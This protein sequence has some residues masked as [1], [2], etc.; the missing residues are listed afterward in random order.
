M[1][2]WWKPLCL[3]SCKEN[4][5]RRYREEFLLCPY[6][7]KTSRTL[8]MKIPVKEGLLA[9]PAAEIQLLEG[10]GHQLWRCVI[11]TKLIVPQILKQTS[12]NK[13]MCMDLRRFHFSIEEQ[14]ARLSAAQLTP[15]A[16]AL[17]EQEL[18]AA[19]QHKWTWAVWSERMWETLGMLSGCHQEEC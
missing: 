19:L 2:V 13:S 12:S 18:S 10:A 11:N 5:C 7:C 6:F 16:R 1:C 8:V 15:P 9:S 4:A 17:S 14:S 3:I